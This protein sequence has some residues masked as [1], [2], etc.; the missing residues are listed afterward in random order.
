[1]MTSKK[2][3][4]L[5]GEL[6]ATLSSYGITIHLFGNDHNPPHFHAYNAD[7]EAQIEISSLEI[8]KGAMPNKMMKVIRTWA[9]TNKQMLLTRFRNLNPTLR[10]N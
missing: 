4:Q 1:M 9:E 10:W 5:L 8:I 6:V 2:S 3:N 7:Y